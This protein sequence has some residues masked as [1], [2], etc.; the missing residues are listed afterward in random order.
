M[1]RYLVMVM[2]KPTF[3]VALAPAHNAF[4]DALRAQQRIELS[5]PFTDKT[6]G[7][8][9]LRAASL[10]EAVDI[11][12]SD[13]LHVERASTVTVHEWNAV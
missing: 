6:G 13:P 4:L 3:D 1:A 7:A 10:A 8:Y 11:A 12:H 9:L 2:R 5:G